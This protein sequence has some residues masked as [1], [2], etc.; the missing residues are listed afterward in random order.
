MMCTVKGCSCVAHARG[1]C[2]K[3]YCKLRHARPRAKR[4]WTEAELALLRELTARRVPDK[5]IAR[6]VNRSAVAVRATR[7][8]R[9]L[10]TKKL[11]KAYVLASAKSAK[12]LA[13]ELRCSPEAVRAIRRNAR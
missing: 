10:G 7:T 11:D 3:H 1:L 5:D 8:Y 2:G 12:E 9:K 6:A 4:E 13:A